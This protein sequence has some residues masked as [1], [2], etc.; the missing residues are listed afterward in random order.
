[1]EL[2]KYLYGYRVEQI[3]KLKLLNPVKDK[4]KVTRLSED[5]GSYR[6][7]SA[8]LPIS[9]KDATPPRPCPGSLVSTLAGVAKRA[10]TKTPKPNRAQL[11]KFKRFTQLWLRHHSGLKPLDPDEIMTFEEWLEKTPYSATRKAELTK[12]WN[13]CGRTASRK[14]LEKL[15]C[16]V[17][18]ETYEEYKF[19]RGIYS[20]S[21]KAKCLFGPLV[22]S[23][24]AKVFKLPWFIKNIPVVD[25]PE[26]IYNSLYKDGAEYVF[27]DYTSFEA[28]FIKIIQQSCEEELYK[29]MF[30]NCPDAKNAADKMSNAKTGNQ[31]VN[32]KLFSVVMEA[33]RASGEMDTSLA[34]GFTNLMLWLF[35]SWQKGC[36]LN[37]IHGFFEGDD[38]ITRN[39]GPTPTAEDFKNMGFTIKIGTT[40]NLNTASFCGQVY[41]IED[42][43][44]VTD[45]REAVCRFGWTAKK[46]ARSGNQVLMELLRA[47]GFSFVYQY[48][49]CPILGKLGAKILQLTENVTVRQSIVDNMDEWERAK[50]NEALTY[51]SQLR[52]PGY[53]TRVLIEKLY[54][55]TRSEQ[56]DIEDK[57]D[58]M[59]ELGVLP[60]SFHNLPNDWKSYYE[61]YSSRLV[62]DPPVWITNYKKRL[63]GSLVDAGALSGSQVYRLMGV[64]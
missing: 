52:E 39:D 10:A 29:Y 13:D 35:L 26:A 14:D 61:S 5:Q 46:Y 60:F 55:V 6:L 7:L 48:G 58:Q 25:R 38:G 45:V 33:F 34:N 41:D 19:P 37:R 3:P 20:R 23:V 17:K 63:I 54:G 64:G 8:R 1:L 15:K 59:T 16:F 44:V 24:A 42:R 22:A 49:G 56:L 2:P 50:Y 28:H 51:G 53:N 43:T 11:R 57:I 27:T 40:K 30:K 18:D 9:Y 4:F 62:D 31:N 47:K 32:F 36:P 12:L 21:D